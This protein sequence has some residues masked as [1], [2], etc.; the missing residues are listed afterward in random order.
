MSVVNRVQV[1][2]SAYKPVPQIF[3]LRTDS[4]LV[5]RVVIRDVLE[6]VECV[7]TSKYCLKEWYRP[8]DDGY[9]AHS[10]MGRISMSPWSI[11]TS[12]TS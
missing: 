4:R 12:L 1:R 5:G 3:G 7:A 10:A 2:D 11:A 8:R 9:D 6:L